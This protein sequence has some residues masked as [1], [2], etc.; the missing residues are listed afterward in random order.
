MLQMKIEPI[1]LEFKGEFCRKTAKL[2]RIKVVGGRR[3]IL[4]C[5]LLFVGIGYYDVVLRCEILSLFLL[6]LA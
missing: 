2:V 3:Q 1:I 5:N 4:K 6:G